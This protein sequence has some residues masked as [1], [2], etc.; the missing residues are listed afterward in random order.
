[1]NFYEF[2]FE[3]NENAV[4]IFFT[5]EMEEISLFFAIEM[6]MYS[7]FWVIFEEKNITIKLMV[8]FPSSFFLIYFVI[9]ETC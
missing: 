4:C 9:V 1:M 3:I 2:T 6:K 7:V 8:I 5:Q